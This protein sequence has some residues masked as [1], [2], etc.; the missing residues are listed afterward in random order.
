MLSPSLGYGVKAQNGGLFDIHRTSDGGQ[1]WTKVTTVDS[2]NAGSGASWATGFYPDELWLSTY[3]SGFGTSGTLLRSTDGVAWERKESGIH[4]LWSN[5]AEP[6][7]TIGKV[8]STG[9]LFVVA[10]DGGK[11]LAATTDHGATWRR[12]DL[13]VQSARVAA[14][15]SHLFVRANTSSSSSDWS[16]YRLAQDSLQELKGHLPADFWLTAWVAAAHDD[17]LTLVDDEASTTPSR[18]LLASSDGGATFTTVLQ[19]GPSGDADGYLLRR[20][21]SV[22]TTAFASLGRSGTRVRI[23]RTRDA[24]TSWTK[25][26]EEPTSTD[27]YYWFHS[28]FAGN[29]YAIQY[30]YYST[31]I[32]PLER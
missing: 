7:G 2:G 9:E 11:A 3:F 12:I 15:P 6:I 25:L 4:A 32:C 16:L 22:G 20:G 19:H 8:L 1:T 27:H 30:S 13:S 24:G 31:A 18:T 28:D 29:V 14:T 10:G 21:I 23:V 26:L 5:L 17:V